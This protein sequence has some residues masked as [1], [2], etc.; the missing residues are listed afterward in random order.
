MSASLDPRRGWLRVLE[1][2]CRQ[3]GHRWLPQRRVPP[4]RCPS[5]D[6][7]SQR[8]A[9][10]PGRQLPLRLGRTDRPIAERA[11]PSLGTKTTDPGAQLREAVTT[12]VAR[13]GFQGLA[14]RL[15]VNPSTISSWRSGRII[16]SFEF[17]TA[18]A[19][20]LEWTPESVRALLVGA[21]VQRDLD[22]P[23]RGGRGRARAKP[24]F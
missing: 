19:T 4:R 15:E 16:P 23:R 6:C 10:A 1:L 11:R 14:Q 21:R 22:R 8:W 13:Y 7:R 5:R 24:A 12:L 9:D 3:C 18:L 17:E 20:H 2:K